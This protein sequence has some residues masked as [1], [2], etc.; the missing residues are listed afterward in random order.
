MNKHQ[1]EQSREACPECQGPTTTTTNAPNAGTTEGFAVD[2][3]HVCCE[4]V[5]V[6][7]TRVKALRDALGRIAAQRTINALVLQDTPQEIARDALDTD[8]EAQG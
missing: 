2:Y 7:N 6:M 1:M 5:Q 4:H 8:K 3:L